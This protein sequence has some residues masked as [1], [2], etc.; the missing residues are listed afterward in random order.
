MPGRHN[1]ATAAVL[2]SLGST[3][4]F[5]LP[6][7]NET[8]L[9]CAA[10]R[11]SVWPALSSLPPDERWRC[12]SNAHAFVCDWPWHAFAEWLATP[13]VPT[14]GAKNEQGFS[15]LFAIQ[16]G[17]SGRRN[18]GAASFLIGEF[19]DRATPALLAR[20]AVLL[21][22]FDAVIYTTASATRECP[23]FRFVIRPSRELADDREYR[24][25]IR[26]VAHR[27]E[28]QPQDSQR[29]RLW[30]RPI[31]GCDTKVFVGGQAWDVDAS[32]GLYSEPEIERA[33][34]PPEVLADVDVQQRV[35]FAWYILDRLAPDGMYACACI[36]H[37]CGVPQEMAAWMIEQYATARGW[38]WDPGDPESRAEHAYEY[39]ANPFGWRI[40]VERIKGL[41]K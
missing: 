15:P 16:P 30:Y 6:K 37:D 29:T 26:G 10:V 14:G 5:V 22:G 40:E 2:S 38:T 27:L 11:F 31:V 8:V 13:I 1:T 23:R 35:R 41:A 12:R 7:S 32:A 25:C 3:K 17:K 21:A 20:T 33:A 4:H 18:G 36:C 34:P 19:D 39:A 28:A 24:A 9:G